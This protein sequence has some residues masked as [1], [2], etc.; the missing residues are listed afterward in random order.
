[1][2]YSNLDPKATAELLQAAADKGTDLVLLDV[3]RED[4]YRSHRVNSAI[5]IPLEQLE[6]RHHEL[7][8]NKKLIIICERGR[9]SVIACEMLHGLGFRD[10]SNVTGGMKQWIA[11]GLAH[12]SG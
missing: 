11:I 2:N 5:L 4:E 8:K 3:R 6:A 1:M 7:D 10:L 9:R 12:V